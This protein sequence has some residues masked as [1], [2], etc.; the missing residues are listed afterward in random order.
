MAKNMGFTIRYNTTNDA[1]Q[2]GQQSKL[3]SLNC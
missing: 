1:N 3:D 2:V